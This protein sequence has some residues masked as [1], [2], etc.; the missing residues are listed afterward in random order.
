MLFFDEK[1][2]VVR[3]KKDTKISV[4]IGFDYIQYGIISD[5]Q[6]KNFTLIEF[7][8]NLYEM[9]GSI[10]IKLYFAL[11]NMTMQHEVKS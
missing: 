6:K 1:S 4:F 5:A 7:I 3:N 8:K 11:Q 10:I 9:F 2:G